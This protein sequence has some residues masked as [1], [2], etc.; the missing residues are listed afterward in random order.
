MFIISQAVARR[1]FS[2]TRITWKMLNILYQSRLQTRWT[3]I[4]MNTIIIQSNIKSS[5]IILHYTFFQLSNILREL[6]LIQIKAYIRKLARI[7]LS[8]I[9]KFFRYFIFI[10]SGVYL[11]VLL[12]IYS[13]LLRK[14][15][16]MSV[17]YVHWYCKF[18]IFPT[19]VWFYSF[20]CH[21]ELKFYVFCRFMVDDVC[22]FCGYRNNFLS[23]FFLIV[24]IYIFGW[25]RFFF[26]L[27]PLSICRLR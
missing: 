15:T 25:L 3:N 23:I 21:F 18:F 24:L 1:R 27:S 17:H 4:L 20:I 9:R 10:S 26:F 8:L 11:P 2:M 16:K 14:F 22:S 7:S 12:I 5:F 19:W 13:S 6:I